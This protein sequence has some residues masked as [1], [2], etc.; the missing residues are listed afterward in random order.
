LSR[1]IRSW[2]DKSLPDKEVIE[3]ISRA[4]TDIAS[5]AKG[6][7]RTKETVSE[8]SMLTLPKDGVT[9]VAVLKV[10]H[11]TMLRALD[12]S[13]PKD[14]AIEFGKARLRITWDGSAAASV[15]APVALFFG[16]GILYNRDQREF[17]VKAFPMVV[18]YDSNRVYLSCY[19]PMPFFRSAKIEL[20]GNGRTNTTDLT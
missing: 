18:R 3:L 20:A 17:L 12:F 4:G 9:Q 19:F 16:A 10:A 15:D 8:Q 1:R 5:P 2:D 13:V 14:Q 11:G 7:R 6:S